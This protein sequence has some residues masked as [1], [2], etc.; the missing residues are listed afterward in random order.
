[1]VAQNTT[2]EDE[3]RGDQ[4]PVDWKSWQYDQEQDWDSELKEWYQIEQKRR[5]AQKTDDEK[6]RRKTIVKTTKIMLVAAFFYLLAGHTTGHVSHQIN[7][8][9][10]KQYLAGK[11]QYDLETNGTANGAYAMSR[12]EILAQ[13]NPLI[14]QQNY[15]DKQEE[16]LNGTSLLMLVALGTLIFLVF[17]SQ[18]PGISLTHTSRVTQIQPKARR[19][20]MYKAGNWK[21]CDPGSYRR[22]LLRRLSAL[23]TP[24]ASSPIATA[25]GHGRTACFC[26]LVPA[27]C[28]TL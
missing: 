9:F 8:S 27:H 5:E 13:D 6:G 1:M 23:I 17:R 15:E 12:S 14:A 28:H 24:D 7:S 11:R 22:L 10:N 18:R 20:S 19:K 21:V 26:R 3:Y 4:D 2:P 25:G 16:S